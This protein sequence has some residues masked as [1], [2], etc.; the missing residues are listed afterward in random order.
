MVGMRLAKPM[1]APSARRTV[2]QQRAMVVRTSNV[3]A[4]GP[5]PMLSIVVHCFQRC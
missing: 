3:A 5:G 4:V 2:R 1:V